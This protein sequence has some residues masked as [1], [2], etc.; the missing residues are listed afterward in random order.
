MNN[1]FKWFRLRFS[2]KISNEV[3]PLMVYLKKGK[4]LGELLHVSNP[5][6][7]YSFFTIVWKGF[8][9]IWGG[10]FVKTILK[11]LG[12]AHCFLQ[13][14]VKKLFLNRLFFTKEFLQNF[15]AKRPCKLWVLSRL[16]SVNNDNPPQ[17]KKENTNEN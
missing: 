16:W 3:I 14:V 2:L 6:L 1:S 13:C 17:N 9:T 11:T 12:V 5:T 7:F 4:S 15:Y 10:S 8:F